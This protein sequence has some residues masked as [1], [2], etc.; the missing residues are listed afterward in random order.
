LRSA[1]DRHDRMRNGLI[2]SFLPR[3]ALIQIT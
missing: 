1:S 3:F 2:I